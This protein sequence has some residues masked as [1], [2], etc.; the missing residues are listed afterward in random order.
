MSKLPPKKLKALDDPFFPDF[1]DKGGPY[2]LSALRDVCGTRINPNALGHYQS[3]SDLIRV[4]CEPKSCA[5][6]ELEEWLGDVSG[7]DARARVR[8]PDVKDWP[9]STIIARVDARKEGMPFALPEMTYFL[10][11][12]SF[13]SSHV[14]GPRPGG[15]VDE[16][17]ERLFPENSQVIL[18]FYNDLKQKKGLWSLLNFWDLPFLDQ[19]DAVLLPDFSAYSSD[20]NVQYMIGERMMQV[21]AE[22]GSRAGRTVIPSI[23]WSTEESLRRQVDL[24]T[25]QT[26]INTIRLDCLGHNVNRTGWTWRWL[27]ALEKYVQGMDHIRWIITGMTTGWSIR[28]LNRIFPKKNYAL[29]TPI[30]TF[31]AAQRRSTDPE[32][33]ALEFRRRI[34]VLQDYRDGVVLADPA[35]RPEAWPKFENLVKR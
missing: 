21:F 11:Y 4:D 8:Q 33:S 15:D 18:S 26:N 2:A 29:V 32:W 23:A 27:F 14:E 12:N 34:R 35:I 3:R 6:P 9:L 1:S 10:D 16:L 5:H 17:R 22:E 24:W 7:L 28:E 25:S 31:I 30:S 13:H 20:P 19:F